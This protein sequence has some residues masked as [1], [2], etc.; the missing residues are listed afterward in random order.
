MVR[1]VGDPLLWGGS[2]PLAEKAQCG[3]IQTLS[4]VWSSR[5]MSGAPDKWP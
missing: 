2:L 4:E 5:M 1:G 3:C